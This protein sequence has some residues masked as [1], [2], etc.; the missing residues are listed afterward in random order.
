MLNE[1]GTHMFDIHE[2]MVVL[3]RQVADRVRSRVCFGDY[4]TRSTFSAV[5]C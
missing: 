1:I 2:D 3:L 5:A 4:G